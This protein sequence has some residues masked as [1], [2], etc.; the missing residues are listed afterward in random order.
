MLLYTR[1]SERR[2]NGTD[3]K[4]FEL[5]DGRGWVYETVNKKDKG[6][7]ASPKRGLEVNNV[8]RS[9]FKVHLRC[10]NTLDRTLVVPTSS[11]FPPAGNG[12][13]RCSAG[14]CG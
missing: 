4:V 12:C 1:V 13:L 14:E 5:S 2:F 3:V 9:G 11:F 7:D 8:S 6:A 10:S